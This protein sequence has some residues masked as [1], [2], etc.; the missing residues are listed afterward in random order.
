M[1]PVDDSAGVDLERAALW[2]AQAAT[3]HFQTAPG[4]QMQKILGRSG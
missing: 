3:V 2:R 4:K 1:Q